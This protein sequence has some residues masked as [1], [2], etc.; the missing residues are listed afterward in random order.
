MHVIYYSFA[1]KLI[2]NVADIRRSSRPFLEE[3]T[4]ED[5][6][7]IDVSIFNYFPIMF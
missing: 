6:F 4:D 1:N 7:Q 5:L 3:K 2:D